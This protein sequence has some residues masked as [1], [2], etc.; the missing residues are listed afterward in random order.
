MEAAKNAANKEDGPKRDGSSKE[1]G[2]RIID[3][4]PLHFYNPESK[5]LFHE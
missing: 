2:E 3:F 4:T 1:T 5:P